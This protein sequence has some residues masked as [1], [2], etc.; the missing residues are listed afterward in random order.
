M[1]SILGSATNYRGKLN[2]IVVVISFVLAVMVVNTRTQCIKSA[3]SESFK[4]N[5]E[6]KWSFKISLGIIIIC[7]LILGFDIAKMVKIF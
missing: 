7:L 3:D 5:N 6:I 2:T 4:E 1:D